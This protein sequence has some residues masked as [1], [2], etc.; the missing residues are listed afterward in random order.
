[1]QAIWL[2]PVAT[3]HVHAQET[4]PESASKA[5]RGGQGA[6]G[7][8]QFLGLGREPD[9]AAAARGEK[10]Y[11]AN[12]SFCHGAKATGAEGPNL[13]RSGVV[14]HDDHGELI[15]QVVTN[16]RPQKGMPAFP[17]LSKEQI[18]DIAEFLHMRVE[19][20]A[21]R[22]TYKRLDIVTGDPKQGES[23]F[24]GAG[25]CS[26]CHS[27]SGDLAHIAAKFPEPDQLQARFAF[28]GGVPRRATVTLDS[29]KSFSGVVKSIDDFH[30]S[31]EDHEGNYHSWSRD[32][33]KRVE[34]SDPLAAHIQLAAHYTDKNMHDLTAYLMTLK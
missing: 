34:I 33:V 11:A 16:G 10:L 28:P 19:L 23:Y 31:I 24:N 5:K 9:A 26:T 32:N 20:V 13:I 18:G 15:G 12:C 22:G 2:I 27:V 6:V 29:G 30:I 3:P 17:N 1:M 14:L 7:T 21:N 8:H 4:R 25:R